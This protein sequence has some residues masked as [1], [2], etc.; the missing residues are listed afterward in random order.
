MVPSPSPLSFS[1]CYPL[2]PPSSTPCT[3]QADYSNSLIR[4]LALSSGVVSTLAGQ[5]GSS[6]TTNGIGTNARFSSPYGIALDAAATFAVVVSREGR[7]AV[8]EGFRLEVG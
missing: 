2:H 3:M 1:T 4:R 7:V 6:G 8:Q 5:A